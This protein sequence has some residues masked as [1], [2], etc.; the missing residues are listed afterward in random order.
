MENARLL[1]ASPAAYP[2]YCRGPSLGGAAAVASTGRVVVIGSLLNW[3]PSTW[4]TDRG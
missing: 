4:I 1:A 2:R 3:I